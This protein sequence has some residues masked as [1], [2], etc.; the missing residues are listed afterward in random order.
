MKRLLPILLILFIS[1]FMI[2]CE[3]ETSTEPDDTAG[4]LQGAY[5]EYWGANE[6]IQGSLNER[7]V[8]LQN[9]ENT[10]YN[11]RGRDVNDEISDYVDTFVEQSN[12]A[13]EG[14]QDLLDLE[15]QIVTYGDDR[16]DDRGDYRGDDRGMFT[17]TAGAICKGIY[18]AGKGAVVSSG[19]MVRSGWRVLS[20]SHSIREAIMAP[21]SGIPIVSDFAQTMHN[22]MVQRDASIRNAILANDTHEGN[23]DINQLEGSTPEEKANFYTNLPDDSALKKSMRGNVHLWDTDE[24]SRTVTTLKDA[25]KRG[26]K[27]YAGA[28]GSG[29]VN[30][31]VEQLVDPGQS[32]TAKGEIRR[33]IRTASSNGNSPVIAT[34][35]LIIS[36][37]N[38]PEDDPKIA[39][40]EEVPEDFELEIPTGVYDFIF[41]AED[42]VRSLAED[43]QLEVAQVSE[44]ILLMY[45]YSNYHLIL[46][47]LTATPATAYI[48]QEVTLNVQAAS[49]IGSD[50]HFDWDISGAHSNLNNEGS[51]WTFVPT[52]MGE[53]TISLTVTDDFQNQKSTSTT[54][55]VADLLLDPFEYEL[56]SETFTD[57]MI[58]PG[59]S[60]GISLSV[61]N[62]GTESVTGVM[63]MEGANGVSVSSSPVT[64]TIPPA[65]IVYHNFSMQL[66]PNFSDPEVEVS[67][68]F[69]AELPDRQIITI[70]QPIVLPVEFYCEINPI[71]SPV[72]ERILSVSGKVANPMLTSA[73]LVID[74]DFD[75]LFEVNL[76]DGTFSASVIVEPSVEEE[77]HTLE[78]I[79][80]SGSLET[81][82]L[83][84]FSSQVAPAGFRVTLTW[85]TT[86]TD[87]DLWVTDPN[88][89]RCYYGNST[90]ASGL[91]LDFDDTN[92]YG[93]ENIT[94]SVPI[95]GDYL[96]QVHY[97]SD[98]D[99][100]IAIGTNCQVIIRLNEGTEDEEVYYYYGFLSDTGDLW[101]VSTFTLDGEAKGKAEESS[102]YSTFNP[103]D[104]PAK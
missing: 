100:D 1:I 11:S 58:N 76:Y 41:T 69:E 80:E 57:D 77:D 21:D 49:L 97:Y 95:L 23:L 89:E 33:E 27:I 17:D 19:Q 68:I 2:S 24:K 37:R 59:E 85:D 16:E 28:V 92:G 91:H 99:D 7:N 32:P 64:V 72:T 6:N 102:T 67:M 98:H 62:D 44:D 55:E 9:I 29:D 96:V 15:N 25:G 74:N 38:Q 86:G 10:F 40:I 46:E 101:S 8:T 81:S 48:D 79:A 87:V 78:L 51:Y 3:D 4:E 70:D 93:P 75:Q 31:I 94:S 5:T 61:R 63:H 45:Q 22:H 50:L 34:K 18:N 53:Y 83:I 104:L 90:T 35:T 20:G 103:D 42:Y 36:K 60:V 43:V 26:V 66:I 82:D 14:F 54:I 13:G 56:T 47:N 84:E 65:G 12:A 88:G 73:Y 30:E 52:E 39:V 71:S